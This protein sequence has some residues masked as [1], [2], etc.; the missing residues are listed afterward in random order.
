MKFW[1]M[2][3]KTREDF[4]L[5]LQEMSKDLKANSNEDYW[6]NPTLER[7]LEAMRSWIIDMD[8]KKKKE[9]LNYNPEELTWSRLKD[10]FVAASIYE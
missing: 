2:E 7:Y 3:V 6:E 9:N 1:D 8:N 4:L 10:I 5:F